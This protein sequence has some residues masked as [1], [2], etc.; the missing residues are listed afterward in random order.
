MPNAVHVALPSRTV[1][2]VPVLKEKSVADF[3]QSASTDPF[4]IEWYMKMTDNAD[5]NKDLESHFTLKDPRY[6]STPS[7]LDFAIVY[8]SFYKHHQ[9]GY[10]V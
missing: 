8:K 5:M 3:I 6:H 4:T 1:P 10:Q 2:M 7:L 9:V